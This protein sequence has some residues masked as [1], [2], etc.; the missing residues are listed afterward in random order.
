MSELKDILIFMSDQHDARINGF[1][2][3]PVVRTPN[4]DLLAKQGTVFDNA[5]TSCPLC[6]P[7]RMSMLASLLPSKTALFDNAGSIPSETSTFLHA[8]GA[9]GYETVLCG[10]MHFEGPDQRHGFAKRIC[11]D[12]TPVYYNYRKNIPAERKLYGMCYAEPGSLKMVGASEHSPV[13]DYD[14]AVTKAAL[15]YL[16]QPHDKPQCIVVG[17]Y[18]PHFPYA[19]PKELFDYYF[20]RVQMPVKQA[21]CDYDYPVYA[22]RVRCEDPQM[23][24]A[25]RATYWG[26]VEFM[27]DLLGQVYSAWQDYLGRHG[28]EGVFVYLS[29]H[30]DQ[31]GERGFYGKTTFFEG[32]A[33]IPLL[34]SGAGIP[35]GKRIFS[36]ASI[37]DLGPT[38]CEMSGAPTLP[39]RDGIS[40]WKEI[41]EDHI[42]CSDRYVISELLDGKNGPMAGGEKTPGRMIVWKNYKYITYQGYE[43]DDLLFDLKNDPQERHNL[44]KEQP[45][46]LKKLFEMAHQDWDLDE[47]MPRYYARSEEM[48]IQME[49]AQ[50]QEL[51]ES[52]RWSC[53]PESVVYPDPLYSAKLDGAAA[54]SP[55][56]QRFLGNM[57]VDGMDADL[58]LEEHRINK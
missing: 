22:R 51:D 40:L 16:A 30:G 17:T 19:V 33:H 23:L 13:L 54:V 55:M 57:K 38:L 35:E 7:A 46:L 4:L 44:A 21:D 5:Y 36:V 9:A 25:I 47:I 20:D 27:D 10:R 52:N 32:S 18:S 49:W 29:D 6:V 24:R 1:A 56:F 50:H 8:L 43:A 39:R 15:D 45:E 28:R 42:D 31:A 3:D 2:G 14:R 11:G 53:P 48:A 41:Q 26:M 12:M 34:F 58:W 37:M